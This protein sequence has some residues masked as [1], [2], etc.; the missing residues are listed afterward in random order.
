MY[1]VELKKKDLP[2]VFIQKVNITLVKQVLNLT[3]QIK[4]EKSKKE[5][6]IQMIVNIL[7]N[8]RINI[9]GIHIQWIHKQERK[10]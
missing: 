6:I 3:K 9:Q 8:Q 5:R 4:I 10:V 7:L 2:Q 1:Q